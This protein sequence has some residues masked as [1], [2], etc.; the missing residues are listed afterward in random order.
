MAEIGRVSERGGS[1]QVEH[2]FLRPDGQLRWLERRGRAYRD[3]CGRVLG[4]RGIVI[5]VTERKVAEQDRAVLL[6]RVTRL[7]AVTSA[8]ARAGTPDEVL[9]VMVGKGVEAMGASAGSVAVL[10]PARSVLV[11]AEAG[12]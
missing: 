6:E 11:V 1:Y 7:Q 3:D 10:D 8:L 5:D 2:R 12:G 9:H 4:V